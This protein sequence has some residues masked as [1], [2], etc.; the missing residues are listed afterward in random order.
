MSQVERSLPDDTWEIVENDIDGKKKIID[1]LIEICYIQKSQNLNFKVMR[2]LESC[3]RENDKLLQYVMNHKAFIKLIK[4]ELNEVIIEIKES[5]YKRNEY[6]EYLLL[7]IS[8][9][10]TQMH[11]NM[12]NNGICR[13]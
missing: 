1:R 13:N 6:H 11:L 8:I 9:M 4:E 3:I 10:V 5:K 7:F 2:I 12:K